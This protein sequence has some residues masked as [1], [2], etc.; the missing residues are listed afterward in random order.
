MLLIT[1]KHV[2]GLVKQQVLTCNEFQKNEPTKINF[3]DFK[4]AFTL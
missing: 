3:N 1:I 2:D 4:K